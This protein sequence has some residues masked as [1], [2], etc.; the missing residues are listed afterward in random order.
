MISLLS[1][2]KSRDRFFPKHD[3][4]ECL[5]KGGFVREL[6]FNQ[7]EGTILIQGCHEQNQNNPL[8][9]IV[10]LVSVG[11]QCGPP[12]MLAMVA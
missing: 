3:I 4:T 7:V 12:V 5:S 6:S 8:L 1:F 9:I 10:W 2:F 11:P